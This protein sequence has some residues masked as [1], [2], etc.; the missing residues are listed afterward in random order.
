[1]A[2]QPPLGG[3]LG[4][5]CTGLVISEVPSTPSE[6]IWDPTATIKIQAELTLDSS[7]GFLLPMVADAA[8]CVIEYYASGFGGL[9][10]GT[11]GTRIVPAG[12]WTTAPALGAATW[13]PD[14]PD[15]EITFT[16]GVLLP[17]PPWPM[18]SGNYEITAIAKFEFL[19]SPFMFANPD[20]EVI[21]QVQ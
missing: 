13:A 10:S 7:F 16:P 9:P 3:F 20:A 1:M 4:I 17:S 11:L 5:D 21:V 18:T 6:Y 12:G 15:T 2:G 8:D 14:L 19:G